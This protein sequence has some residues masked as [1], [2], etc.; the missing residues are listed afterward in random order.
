MPPSVIRPSGGRCWAGAHSGCPAEA[1]VAGRGRAFRR[2]PPRGCRCSPGPGGALAGGSHAQQEW[3]GSRR[4]VRK[5]RACAHVRLPFLWTH[6]KTCT[7]VSSGERRR[8][9]GGRP[10]LPFTLELELW[11][12][13]RQPATVPRDRVDSGGRSQLAPS[14][15][16]RLA[17]VPIANVYTEPLGSHVT[18]ERVLSPGSAVPTTLIGCTAGQP[19]S[20]S[21]W[22]PLRPVLLDWSHVRCA[23]TRGDG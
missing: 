17:A 2:P 14:S 20:G 19:W 9:G 15:C 3:P 7:A 22:P 4:R 12:L 16:A 10:S 18:W 1:W 13:P 11:P 21:V 8:Q 5:A 6:R 23:R